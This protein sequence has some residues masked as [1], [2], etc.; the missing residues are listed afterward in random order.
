[1]REQRQGPGSPTTSRSMPRPSRARARSRPLGRPLDR[2]PQ[3][4]LGHRADQ[5]LVVAREPRQ[6]P[7]TGA[8]A[9]EVGAQHDDHGA[10]RAPAASSR[11]SMKACRSASSRQSVKAP[12]TGRRRPRSA[13]APRRAA[14]WTLAGRE[15][16]R[17]KLA[18][19][20]TPERG[21]QPRA[22]ERRLAAS[23]G[24][25]DG[26]ERASSGAPTS[27][28]TSASR[29]KKA[30]RPPARRRSKSLVRTGK[31]G[32]GKRVVGQPGGLDRGVLVCWRGGGKLA[33]Q[34]VRHRAGTDAR[35]RG[36][37]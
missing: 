32:G 8:V 15:D 19:R 27:S 9:V 4:V 23:R 1:M 17:A 29:P 34:A 28:P 13:P 5:H 21:H 36:D 7:G 22:H 25:D 24:P 30:P 33:R 6:A 16:R 12:R 26:E 10:T 37:P 20:S 18:I 11:R 2:A 31:S 35:A 3:L 14:E